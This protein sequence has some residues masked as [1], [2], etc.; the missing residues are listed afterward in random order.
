MRQLAAARTLGA[1]APG[2]SAR[3]SWVGPRRPLSR[4]ASASSGSGLILLN[5]PRWDASAGADRD[6]LAIAHA[7]MGPSAPT[8]TR[9]VLTAFTH[10]RDCFH[11]RWQVQHRNPVQ[12]SRR[13]PGPLPNIPQPAVRTLMAGEI[14]S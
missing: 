1:T 4:I 3:L 10:V 7:R 8:R 12:L 9:L 11:R 5:H 14:S 2:L 13:S 6:A